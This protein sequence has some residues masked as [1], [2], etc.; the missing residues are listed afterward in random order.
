[1]KPTTEI[2]IGSPLEG[3][4]AQFLVRLCSDLN[5]TCLILANL[6]VVSRNTSR[7]IDFLIVNETNR[8]LIELKCF[9]GPVVGSE[10]GA[11]TLQDFAR[12]LVAY[13][14]ENPWNQAVQAKF[15]LSDEMSAFAKSHPE[16]PAAPGMH[17]YKEFDATVCIFPGVHPDS[18][19]TE[20]NYKA[21][22]R[23]Y[24]DWLSNFRSR[25]LS[26]SWSL[27]QWRRFAIEHLSLRPVGLQQAI[28]SRALSASDQVDAY[29]K[30][31]AR[32]LQSNPPIKAWPE[33]QRYGA[34]L[35]DDLLKPEHTVLTGP[36]GCGKS[37][38]VLHAAAKALDGSEVPILVKPKR[39]RGADFWSLVQQAVAPFYRGSAKD[40][41]A[42]VATSGRHPLLVVDGLNE[43]PS[44]L[45]SELN[46]GIRAF[47][48]QYDARLLASG[49]NVSELPDDLTSNPIEMG[50]PSLEQKRA[51]YEHYANVA[52]EDDVLASFSNAYDLS[53]A[54]KCHATGPADLPRASLYDRY[55]RAQLPAKSQTPCLALLRQLAAEM[56]KTLSVAISRDEFERLAEEFVEVNSLPLTLIDETRELRL[57]DMDDETVS[58]EHE[59][60]FHYFRCEHLRRQCKDVEELAR[61]LQRPS[62]QGLQE[63]VLSRLSSEGEIARI[64]GTCKD[65]EFLS[66]ALTGRCGPAVSNVVNKL[67]L[68]VFDEAVRDLGNI[69][70]R[71]ESVEHENGGRSVGWAFVEGNREWSAFELLLFDAALRNIGDDAWRDRCLALYDVT[72]TTLS[73]A[74]SEAATRYRF[75]FSGVWRE[76]VRCLGRLSGSSATLPALSLLAAVGALGTCRQ[77]HGVLEAIT[78]RMLKNVEADPRREFSLLLLLAGLRTLCHLGH[79]PSVDC[80]IELLRTSCDHATYLTRIDAIE[81]FRWIRQAVEEHHRDRLA[82]IRDA[83]ESVDTGDLFVNT[84]L[85]EVLATYEFLEPPVSTEQALQEFRSFARP[86][87]ELTSEFAQLADLYPEMN[88]E[89][90][91]REKC[92]STIGKIFEDVFG[93]AYCEAYEML[94]PDEKGAIL[95]LAAGAEKAGFHKDWILSELLRLGDGASL[96]VFKKYATGIEKGSSFI[97]EAVSAFVISVIAY[98]RLSDSRLEMKCGDT[99]DEQAWANIGEIL[100][101]HERRN[102]EPDRS[103]RHVR[104]LWAKAQGAIAA[105]IPDVIFHLERHFFGELVGQN[106]HLL[107]AYPSEICEV[108]KEALRRRSEIS[109]LWFNSGV[110]CRESVSY[111]ISVLSELGDSSCADVLHELIDDPSFGEE[112]VRAVRRLRGK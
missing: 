48:R 93:S 62:N 64:I 21:W 37:Y 103:D 107:E 20:G 4:E 54:G 45:I 13:A 12:N 99:L 96:E 52:G 25:T 106:I 28:D 2:L 109:S 58:F 32:S 33:G 26:T 90:F 46:A 111:T 104:E 59:L 79:P 38:H 51:I 22:V 50:S 41:L 3:E 35:V 43:C 84:S 19:L 17:F 8:G 47:L 85:L 97:N 67:C 5:D 98:A 9:R 65:A 69:C 71:I 10:N 27:A 108:F 63:F 53:L 23:G 24:N 88:F 110:L 18:K 6:E 7:Q 74:A 86:I 91:R 14:G 55:C 78:E 11:W 56:D 57:L 16:I 92:Y 75:K 68:E 81:M 44:G 105:A 101:W 70:L 102:K 80:C 1:M 61:E 30:T 89:Q 100:F 29:C 77:Q 76:T 87:T 39:Y 112:A 72:E 49:Q 40:L 15:A 73:A 94:D 31:L 95:T 66:K 42:A 60:L 36:S 82:D 83:L 34:A